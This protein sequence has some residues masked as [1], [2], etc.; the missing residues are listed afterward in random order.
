MA[1]LLQRL[2][3]LP[4]FYRIWIGN[5]LIVVGGALIGTRLTEAFVERGMFSALT[6]ALLVV[7]ALAISAVVNFL[8][9][10]LALRPLEELTRAARRFQQGDPDARAPIVPLGDAH[11]TEL[12]RALNEMWD[13]M[14]ASAATIRQNNRELQRLAAQVLSA[15]ED[16]RRRVARELHDEASQA[17]TTLIIGLE[18]G[19][20]DMTHLEQPREIVRKLRDLAVQTLDEIRNLAYDL[21]PTMLD[22]LG[23][24]PAVRW[25]GRNCRTRSGLDVAVEV[26]GLDERLPPQIETALYRIVQEGLT[27]V[28]KHAR[29]RQ[30]LVR[31]WQADGLV[32]AEV[33]DDGVGIEPT[34]AHRPGGL[35]VFGMRERTALLGGSFALGPRPAPERGTRLCVRIPLEPSGRAAQHG[36]GAPLTRQPAVV[37]SFLAPS[38]SAATPAPSKRSHATALQ[39]G[40]HASEAAGDQHDSR[41]ATAHREATG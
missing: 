18:R 21:R 39:P 25:Y 17:L 20:Q 5:S 40:A 2:R 13:R 6:Y 28:I 31:L 15:Q 26:T 30:A 8:L 36:A 34:Q 1:G 11:M 3:A 41:A 7:C 35:G 19:M 4:L 9:L 29:A 10:K 23:L 38:Q 24:V 37:Q 12:A 14:E 22:D 33:Y 16:E 27:N 32:T